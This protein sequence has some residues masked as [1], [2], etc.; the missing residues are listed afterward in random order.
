MESHMS[1]TT[2]GP[3]LVGQLG[4]LDEV[5]SGVDGDDHD[6]DDDYDECGEEVVTPP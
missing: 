6:G 2:A 3:H 4:E 1:G 5:D